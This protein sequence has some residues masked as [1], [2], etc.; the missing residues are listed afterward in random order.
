MKESVTQNRSRLLWP[1]LLGWLALAVAAVVIALPNEEDDLTERAESALAT[2]G[3]SA[4]V[5][6]NGRDATLDGNLTPG[7]EERALEIVRNLR[8]VRQADWETPVQASPTLPP[9]TTTTTAPSGDTTT[10]AGQASTTTAPGEFDPR[11]TA[12][13]NRGALT[14]GGAIPS[15]EAAAQVAGVADLVYGPFVTNDLAV[16]ETLT[17]LPWVPNAANLMAVL[18]IVGDAELSVNG[19]KAT[20]TGSAGTEEKKA[21]LEAAIGAALG[22]EVRL[23]SSIDVTNLEPPVYLAQAPGDGTVTLSGTMPDQAAIDLIAGA[24]VDAFGADNVT[25]DMT[26]GTGID[27]TFSIFRIPLTFAQFRPIPE[28]ELRIEDDVISGN[29]RGGATFDFGSAELTPELRTLLD[30]GAGILLRNPSVLMT[31]E[32]HT[33]S[34]GSDSFN[35]ALSEARAQAGADYLIARGVQAERLFPVGFGETQPIADNDTAEGRRQNRRL[36]F[37]LGPPS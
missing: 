27:T 35:L 5:D 14:L 17:A 7:D 6:F 21:Q 15:A 31:I 32:G 11:L 34:V 23:V 29:V 16:D 18:P 33:D 13:L 3:I 20:L 19:T 10:T 8:G 9:A 28:W 36:E 25:N 12:T 1:L 2:A 24:A 26:I 22:P 30:T 37:V 4:T